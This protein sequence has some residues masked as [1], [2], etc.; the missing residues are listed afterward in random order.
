MEQ[1]STEDLV[2][3]TLV[4][5]TY[6]LRA[7]PSVPAY[8]TTAKTAL[9]ILLLPI[10]VPIGLVWAAAMATPL[11]SWMISMFIPRI[12]E[13]VDK[14]FHTEREKLLSGISGRV[15]D[16]GSG[17]GAYMRYLTNAQGPVEV[18]AVEPVQHMHPIIHT[19]GKSLGSSLK[20]VNHLEDLKEDDQESFD[21][22]IFGNVLCE[23]PDVRQTVHHVVSRLLKP[24]GK[25]YFQEHIAQKEGSW[26]RKV[27]DFVNPA[28]RHMGGGCNCNR[29]SVAIMKGHS[30]WEGV[31]EWQ[32]NHYTVA[33][34]PMVLGLAQKKTTPLK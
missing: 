23:V 6:T 24:G 18:V 3:K 2:S 1:S 34:G 4:G 22:V 21:W 12:M 14:E 15:L 17:G 31:V 5:Q 19:A 30:S 16:V 9:S 25:V 32:Y 27:Q 29:D 7:S 33:L 10:S 26:Q 11:R 28:W 13:G 8:Q 20:I